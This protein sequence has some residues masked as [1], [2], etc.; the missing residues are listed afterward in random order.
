MARRTPR[1]G[2]PRLDRHG[3]HLKGLG[4]VMRRNPMDACRGRNREDHEPDDGS[5]SSA[6]RREGANSAIGH[7]VVV[8]L[9]LIPA[10]L[11]STSSC[12]AEAPGAARRS[13]R[14]LAL[15]QCS[16]F[17]V[18]LRAGR[19][20]WQRAI[21]TTGSM[22]VPTE[23]PRLEWRPAHRLSSGEPTMAWWDG[24]E[25]LPRVQ[26]RPSL[27]LGGVARRDQQSVSRSRQVREWTFGGICAP[28]LRR[29][30]GKADRT[31]CDSVKTVTAKIYDGGIPACRCRASFDMD[32]AHWPDA[33]S[34]NGLPQS[35]SGL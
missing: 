35:Q 15:R 12:G 32:G 33:S 19:P 7:P 9:G 4:L 28:L 27:R 1:P 31:L 13:V 8:D 2:F 34:C 16:S 22:T 17:Q 5:L 10:P 25:I 18:R 26:A 30:D 21:A 20:A 3:N 6:L 24:A 29:T 23:F 14:A 11:A